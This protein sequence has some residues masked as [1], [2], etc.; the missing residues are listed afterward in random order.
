M[1][2]PFLNAGGGKYKGPSGRLFTGKQV[3]LY[4]SL[5]GKFPGQKKKKK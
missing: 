4:Y 2:M 3:K 5:G 1:L